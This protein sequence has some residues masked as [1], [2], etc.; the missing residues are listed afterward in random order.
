MVRREEA[1]KQKKNRATLLNGESWREEWQ[2][3]QAHRAHTHTQRERER[4]R[5]RESSLSHTQEKHVQE[6]GRGTPPPP[7]NGSRSSPKRVVGSLVM[8]AVVF[9]HPKGTGVIH[10]HRTLL[11]ER[12]CR[13]AP[14][15]CSSTPH[16]F[17]ALAARLAVA[18]A[19]VVIAVVL[20][21]Q[22]PHQMPSSSSHCCA[23]VKCPG[24]TSHSKRLGSPSPS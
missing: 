8:V 16:A 10:H 13:R 21:V 7:R 23:W 4:E 18:P 24:F 1:S 17:H 11:E 9:Q 3:L 5:E 15:C 19:F 22:A 2:R 12:E 20:D 6:R 14:T